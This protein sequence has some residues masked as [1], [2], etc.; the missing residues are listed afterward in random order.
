MLNAIG[1]TAGEIWQTLKTQGPLSISAIASRIK[2]PQ[3]M[4]YMGIGWLAREDKLIFTR[5]KQGVSVSLK[6]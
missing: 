1:E 5:T 4:V 6:M 3:T 2:R